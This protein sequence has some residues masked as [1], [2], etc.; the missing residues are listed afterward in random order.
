MKGEKVIETKTVKVLKECLW[1]KNYHQRNVFTTNRGSNEEPALILAVTKFQKL[2]FQK[3]IFS[4]IL[5]LLKN[6]VAKL[7]FSDVAGLK[8]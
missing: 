7:S 5:Y 3:L 8:K 2:S 4:A 6:H 1:F